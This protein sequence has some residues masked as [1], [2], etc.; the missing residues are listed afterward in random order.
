MFIGFIYL[1]LAP[2]A[3]CERLGLEPL[4][5]A[6]VDGVTTK[7]YVMKERAPLE[8][9][10]KLTIAVR[11]T[12]HAL[13]EE[14]LMNVSDPRSSHYGHHLNHKEVRDFIAPA[15]ES[16]DAVMGWLAAYGL[17]GEKTTHTGDFISVTLTVEQ[18]EGLL[19]TRY[20]KYTHTESGYEVTRVH[21]GE[22]SEQP[23]TVP[24]D[25]RPHLDF[26]APTI[27]FPPPS[28][29]VKK[30]MQA[31]GPDMKPDVTPPIL[32]KLYNISG[33]GAG[34]SSNVTQGVASFIKQYYAKSD[35]EAFWKKYGMNDN[36][37]TW[38]DVPADQKHA[39]IGTEASLDVQWISVSGQQVNT[40]HWSTEGVQ[41]GNS[42]NEPFTTWLEKMAKTATVPSV[43]SI[44]YGDEETGVS[45]PY[46]LRCGTEFQAAGVRGISLLTASGDGGVG[47]A[48]GAFVPTFPASCPWVTAVGGTSG[49]TPGNSPSGESVADLS[50]G[51]FSNYF[52]RPAFQTDAVARYKLTGSLPSANQWNASGAGFPDI[53]AQAL[54]YDTCTQDFFYPISGTSCACPAAS[55]IFSRLNQNRASQ[56][57]PPLGFLN[58]MIYQIAPAHAADHVFNDILD[59]VNAH[60]GDDDGFPAAKGWDA[61]TGWGTLNY[62]KLAALV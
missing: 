14:L 29:L 37:F 41:P 46:A 44:S 58:P 30:T 54:L 50:G 40:E 5:Q 24:S 60:C 62:G 31:G 9:K 17:T 23:Y 51:G 47:C 7:G 34:K 25:I 15:P 53:A 27:T 48:I 39:P 13:L 4:S 45:K 19:Q 33:V 22:A 21:T 43:F 11:Q 55:G 42:E 6:H 38:T 12:N 3:A 61:V 57:K 8:H 49:G 59:G 52:P 36:A 20:M 10:L 56:G 28:L 18:A 35:L 16:V 1:L 26:I 2:F 32:W